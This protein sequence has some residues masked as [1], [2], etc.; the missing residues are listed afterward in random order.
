MVCP[1]SESL[2]RLP[3]L[4]LRVLRRRCPA[5]DD[6]VIDPPALPLSAQA[7]NS[8]V[9]LPM[10]AA[11]GFVWNSA[12][13]FGTV[14]SDWETARLKRRRF[15][16]LFSTSDFGVVLESH[17]DADSCVD[18]VVLHP[19]AIV[20][21]SPGP[22]T[23]TA[24]ILVLLKKSFVASFDDLCFRVVKPGRWVHIILCNAEGALHLHFLHIDMT[25]SVSQHVENFKMLS[26][27]TQLGSDG[28]AL[29]G[30]DFNFLP[31][32]E[33][34][35]YFDGRQPRLEDDGLASHWDSQL[36]HLTE[37]RQ[38]LPTR[39]GLR[40]GKPHIAA[41]LDRWYT[42]LPP[43][44]L[45]DRRPLV[46]TSGNLLKTAPLSDHVPICC[47]LH[48]PSLAPPGRATVPRWV[49][50]HP[51]F[52]TSLK[53]LL[54]EFSVERAP[55][56]LA[57]K[58][59]KECMHAAACRVKAA[60]LTTRAT[61]PTENLYLAKKSYRLARA[62]RVSEATAPVSIAWLRS[63]GLNPATLFLHPRAQD[64]LAE[65]IRSM[66][67]SAAFSEAQEN[68][69]LEEASA[70]A[71]SPGQLSLSLQAWRK[72]K[73]AVSMLSCSTDTSCM[74]SH[75]DS[76][77][78]LADHWGKVFSD[79]TTD[80]TAMN[81]ILAFIP[82]FAGAI[83]MPTRAMLTEVASSSRSSAPGQDGIDFSAWRTSDSRPLDVVYKLFSAAWLSN[84]P[85]PKSEIDYI[86]VFPPK[87]TRLSG[88]IAPSETR[89]IALL[90]T[91]SKLQAAL[92]N[93]ALAPAAEAICAPHQHGFLRGRGSTEA[94]VELDAIMSSRTAAKRPARA[95]S[96]QIWRLR[97]R[98]CRGR[99]YYIQSTTYLA[100]EAPFSSLLSFMSR[101]RSPCWLLVRLQPSTQQPVASDKAAP[102]AARCSSLCLR[103][104]C[105]C[106]HT[107]SRAA[108]CYLPLL[109][110]WR[111]TF[112]TSWLVCQN[113]EQHLQPYL[114]LRR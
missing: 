92:A 6:I 111:F 66:A 90:N 87:N 22:S 101:R 107:A 75:A 39:L 102:S 46:H 28:F 20:F 82:K 30:G 63:I 72:D 29:I 74:V 96:S 44:E 84:S 60:L 73:R 8:F 58:M 81:E 106:L 24:G 7:E 99:F 109:T 83:S 9:R 50:L 4:G 54:D 88:I 110:I 65:H 55:P 26:L 19:E 78:C 93:R 112:V 5:F 36:P 27:A 42:S 2:R 13:F 37:L 100:L 59:V 17:G 38:D 53:Q 76:A 103:G 51:L 31:A 86:S 45:L 43:M 1:P 40:E 71:R 34:R 49:A 52:S 16:L 80:I 77:L 94:F 11:R 104:S 113:S 85:Q 12:S 79:K 95:F 64:L 10:L 68:E 48:R 23:A 97:F 56:E 35:V 69:K 15:D 114:A 105:A 70:S 41:R 89:P 47:S 62:G 14:A 108:A 25:L 98:R 33:R 3:R 18:M 91:S 32:G 61:T 57:L 67:E 21:S